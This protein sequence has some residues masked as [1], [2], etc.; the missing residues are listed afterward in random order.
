MSLDL[1]DRLLTDRRWSRKRIAN[2]LAILLHS[3]FV[4]AVE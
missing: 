4:A 1:L 3:T 2:Q